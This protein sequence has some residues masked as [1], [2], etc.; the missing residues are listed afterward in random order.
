M[1]PPLI[2]I[3][4]DRRS[5]MGKTNSD[6]EYVTVAGERVR[7]AS[8]QFRE[9][10]PQS[11]ERLLGVLLQGARVW[12]DWRATNPD[13]YVDLRGVSLLGKAVSL[14]GANLAKA[15]LHGAQ[16]GG[17]SLAG[18]DLSASNLY[19]ATLQSANL[20]GAKLAG[21]HLSAADLN[22]ADMTGA[23]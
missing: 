21:A 12:N 19:G 18:A 5:P 4:L 3:A 1:A 22:V 6:D 15:N 17:I 11:T 8:K 2:G 10:D 9:P 7:L 16:L 23:D 14:D 13:V 20:A